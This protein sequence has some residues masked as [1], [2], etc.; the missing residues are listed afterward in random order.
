M[1]IFFPGVLVFW[2]IIHTNIEQLRPMGTRA[3]WIAAFAWT[4]TA[5]PILIFRRRI[6]SVRWALS[7]PMGQIVAG[8][9]VVVFILAGWLLRRATREIPITT[10]IGLPEINPGKRLQ[11][12]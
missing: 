12:V 10:M 1:V 7:E 5:G 6:F 3:Y 11:P 8:A 4:I 9:G 2:L